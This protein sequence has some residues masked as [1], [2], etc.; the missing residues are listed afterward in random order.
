MG[1]T[2]TLAFRV[3]PKKAAALD[4]LAQSTER[5]KAWLLEQ[6]LGAC[7]VE[8]LMPR[9]HLSGGRAPI[10]QHQDFYGARS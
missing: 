1:E 8:V 6:A 5:T 10:A 4:K 3:P 9:P 2:V 7:A